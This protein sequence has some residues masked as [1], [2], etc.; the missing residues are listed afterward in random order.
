[1]KTKFSITFLLITALIYSSCSMLTP[2][3]TNQSN[4]TAYVAGK[5]FGTSLGALYSHYKSSGKIVLND[6]TTLL[7][8]T[9]LATY[10][11]S[12]RGIAKNTTTYKDFTTGI[13]AGSNNLVKSN[14]VDNII[15]SVNNL[16]L[17]TVVNSL[18]NRTISP[19]TTSTVSNSL[20]NILNLL[21]KK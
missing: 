9:E 18:N 17:S 12:V 5:G 4:S 8:L 14:V 6:A 2:S 15:S 20:S 16:N 7:N 3:S 10:G 13:I 11:A 19:T 21:G 1:M